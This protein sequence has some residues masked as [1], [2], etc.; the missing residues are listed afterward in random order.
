MVLLL[1]LVLEHL[2]FLVHQQLPLDPDYLVFPV[3]RMNLEHPGSAFPEHL[4]FLGM[5]E[6]LSFPERQ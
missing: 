3:Q 2:E 5:P 1:R 4:E 6:H